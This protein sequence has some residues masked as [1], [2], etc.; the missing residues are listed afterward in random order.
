MK[1]ETGKT[2][3][4]YCRVSSVD[5]IEGTSLESQERL[6]RDFAARQ[7]WAVHDVF[8]ERG[9]SAKTADRDELNRAIVFCKAHRVDYFLVYK[10]DRF[11]RNQDDHVTVRAV[12]RRAGTELQSVTEPIDDSP[13]GRAMEGILSVFAELD[14][15]IRAERTRQGMR[16]RVRQGVWVWKAPLG[17]K[18]LQENANIS[19]DPTTAP[20]IRLVFEEYAKGLYSL[21][22]LADYV[23]SRGLVTELGRKPCGQLIHRILRNPLY[24]GTM[25]VRGEE[26]PGAFEPIV[27]PALYAMCQALLRRPRNGVRLY[28]ADNPQFPLRRLVVCAECGNSLTGSVSQGRNRMRYAYYHHSDRSCSVVRSIPRAELEKSFLNYLRSVT[29]QTRFLKVFRAAVL[30]TLEEMQ[31]N[32]E[33]HR[34]VLARELASL[35]QERQRIFDFHRR[36]V[37]TDDEFRDQMAKSSVAVKQKHLLM[38]EKVPD[39]RDVEALLDHCVAIVQRTAESWEEFETEPTA[40]LRLQSQVF[41]GPLEFDGEYFRNS[42]LSLVYQL[43]RERQMRKN[44]LVP[45]IRENWKQVLTDLLAWGELSKR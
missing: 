21:D 22:R 11:A 44:Q 32:Q 2:C 18:R 36:G 39:R 10:L 26:Y 3:I 15:N 16:E 28:I 45:F 30:S 34:L 12:L 35:E 41:T 17:Y 24:A 23:A 1:L 43:N 25:C 5:Q 9:V 42:N 33:Q 13:I 29:P 6:C 20:L 14:N 27:S 31:G 7:G 19:P 4:I 38:K 40:R 37:Y 8:I